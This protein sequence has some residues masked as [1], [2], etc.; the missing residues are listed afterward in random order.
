M[1]IRIGPVGRRCCELAIASA[2]AGL[3]VHA[4]R[5]QAQRT[6][7]FERGVVASGDWLQ[8]NAL[9]LDRD[10]FQSAAAGVS[11]RVGGWAIDG[12]WLRVARSLSTVQGGSISFGRLLPWK[13][14]LFIPAVGGFVGRGQRS[15]DSTGFDFVDPATGAVGHTPRYS[16]SSAA[17][18]GGGAGLTLEVPLYRF[19]AARGVAWQWWF[20]GDPLEGDRSRT[21]LGA[22]LSVR[23]RGAR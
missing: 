15:V 11:F 6:A 5:L 22:G 23:L 21:V 7:V 19:V 10:A 20:T 12:G 9:P 3:C 1:I 8:A 18:L 14:L 13:R 2:V 16:Y 17:S 4:P